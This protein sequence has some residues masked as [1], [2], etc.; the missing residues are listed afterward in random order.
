MNF[1]QSCS[2]ERPFFK[3]FALKCKVESL[4]CFHAYLLCFIIVGT[5]ILYIIALKCNICSHLLQT[6]FFVLP[7]EKMQ[8]LFL[9]K[10]LF[11]TFNLLVLTAA[12]KNMIDVFNRVVTN[13]FRIVNP[14]LNC[15]ETVEPSK[16]SLQTKPP[17]YSIFPKGKVS[18]GQKEF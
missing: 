4:L 3:K 9:K 5:K 12:W 18:L 13:I 2:N 11:S 14:N 6:S 8:F 7:L 17:D 10:K 1:L 15:W 16:L